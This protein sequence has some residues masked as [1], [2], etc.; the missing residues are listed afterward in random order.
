MLGQDSCE[1]VH[2]T[3]GMRIVTAIVLANAALDVLVPQ[4]L[5][6]PVGAEVVDVNLHVSIADL[7]ETVST[8]LA[9]HGD[10]VVLHEAT[11]LVGAQ[12]LLAVRALLHAP[13]VIV[14][15][16]LPLL[17]VLVVAVT[18][19]ALL[20]AEP[21]P[22]LLAD[23]TPSVT[24][25]LHVLARIS[26]VAGLRQPAPRL[27][28]H[29]RSILPGSAF[30]VTLQPLS[31][32]VAWPAAGQLPKVPDGCV[33][34]VRGDELDMVASE[35]GRSWPSTPVVPLAAM[36]SAR[37][38]WGARKTTEVVVM[39]LEIDSLRLEL[40]AP[41]TLCRWCHQPARAR[42]CSGCSMLR[43]DELGRP[44]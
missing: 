40:S 17:G 43:L 5:G 39:P 32:V 31:S 36:D 30:M 38:W 26:S 15:V 9:E 3:G 13:I 2:V 22:T 35:I 25:R 28:Q 41:A 11:D 21:R 16:A 14:P 18:L 44:A 23:L 19:S 42:L 8:L 4:S 34:V 37:D 27:T 1:F 20:P 7:A 29:A 10:L 24:S 33:A 12:A 6:L